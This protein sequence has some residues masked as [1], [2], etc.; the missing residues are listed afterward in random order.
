MRALLVVEIIML[1]CHGIFRGQDI[2]NWVATTSAGTL[3][4]HA[5]IVLIRDHGVIMGKLE[6]NGSIVIFHAVR[7]FVVEVS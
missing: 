5:Q 4:Q 7:M 3:D 2:R 1:V 6:L